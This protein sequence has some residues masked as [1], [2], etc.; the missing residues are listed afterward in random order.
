MLFAWLPCTTFSLNP[1][2]WGTS[3]KW[4]HFQVIVSSNCYV[5]FDCSLS[6]MYMDD[7]TSSWWLSARTFFCSKELA[8]CHDVQVNFWFGLIVS[9]NNCSSITKWLWLRC[10]PVQ[11]LFGCIFVLAVERV[12]FYLLRTLKR[13][14]K[15]NRADE[16]DCGLHW[17]WSFFGALVGNS[18]E[19]AQC[20]GRLE[21]YEVRTRGDGKTRNLWCRTAAIIEVSRRNVNGIHIADSLQFWE[22][23]VQA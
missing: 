21:V 1:I 17:L 11:F 7:G 22:A 9:I 5:R 4:W 23:W 3:K 19:S 2:L 15:R 14:K 6:V 12:R 20:Y 10:R 18:V 16:L 13:Q 8:E